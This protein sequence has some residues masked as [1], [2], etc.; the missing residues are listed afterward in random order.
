MGREAV[1]ILMND[2]TSAAIPLLQ[3]SLLLADTIQ[4][5]GVLDRRDGCTS[6][7]ESGKIQPVCPS[8]LQLSCAVEAPLLPK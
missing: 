7:R 1:G 3:H 2:S 4:D 5:P 8:L 6:E